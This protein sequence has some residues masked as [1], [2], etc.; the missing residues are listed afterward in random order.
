[1]KKILFLLLLMPLIAK[2]QMITVVG[3]T[4]DLKNHA[5][6]RMV[7]LEHY[8]AGTMNGGGFFI[9]VDSAY[10]ENGTNAFDYP[11]DGY[12]WARLNLVDQYVRPASEDNQLLLWR[13]DH[14]L[15]VTVAAIDSFYTSS[16]VDTI[17]IS[18]I[19]TNSVFQFT[20]WTPTYGTV[21]DSVNYSYYTK[22]DTCFVTRT[23]YGVDKTYKSGAQYTYIWIK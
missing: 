10:I 22:Q 9:R 3:D 16:K 18:G 7:L 1:M 14:Y 17:A 8:A 13:T 21:I 20:D 15:P 6:S 5:G 23:A 2:A 19:D 11:Y 12:Q 4:T